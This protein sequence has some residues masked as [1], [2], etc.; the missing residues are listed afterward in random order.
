MERKDDGSM[1]FGKVKRHRAMGARERVG[2]Q[3]EARRKGINSLLTCRLPP[4]DFGSCSNVDW[5]II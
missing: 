3:H 4:K 1:L 5:T 2:G